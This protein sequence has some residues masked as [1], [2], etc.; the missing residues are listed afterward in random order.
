VL[1]LV[2]KGYSNKEISKELSI[3]ENT[4]KTHMKNILGKLQLDNRVQLAS[5]AYDKGFV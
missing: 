2:A 4:V 5:Y 3:S 1:Q